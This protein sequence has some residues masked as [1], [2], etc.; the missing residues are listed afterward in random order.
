MSVAI[1]R[2][3]NSGCMGLAGGMAGHPPC[4]SW[5]GLHCVVGGKGVLSDLSPSPLDWAPPTWL[6]WQVDSTCCSESQ[7]PIRPVIVCVLI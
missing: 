6:T 1:V 2:L 7:A 5:E 3:S 4:G